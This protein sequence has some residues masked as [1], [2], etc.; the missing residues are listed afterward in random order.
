MPLAPEGGEIT[1]TA[2]L[3]V[4]T[5]IAVELAGLAVG[6]AGLNPKQAGWRGVK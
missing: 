1:A 3:G 2:W 5:A 6:F 4:T